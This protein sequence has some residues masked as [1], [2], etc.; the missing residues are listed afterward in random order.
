MKVIFSSLLWKLKTALLS[1]KK[2]ASF[3]VEHNRFTRKISAPA[4]SSLSNARDSPITCEDDAVI[5][6]NLNQLRAAL[7]E[8][9]RNV[10]EDEPKSLIV[11]FEPIQHFD[12]ASSSE[13]PAA[14]LEDSNTTP[15][16]SVGPNL[17]YMTMSECQQPSEDF[18]IEEDIYVVVTPP[19]HG[20]TSSDADYALVDY[21]T[22]DYAT[23]DYATV[24]YTTVD[25]AQVE[26]EDTLPAMPPS[27]TSV[28]YQEIDGTKTGAAK[29]ISEQRLEELFSKLLK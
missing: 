14:N 27:M 29:K 15:F 1:K 17:E 20:S 16:F 18:L 21:A 8:L 24:D 28:I 9:R 26:L 23:V 22:V 19:S 2:S 11:G 25:Y 3:N 12:N 4:L 5:V 13:S 6:C 7:E 10:L